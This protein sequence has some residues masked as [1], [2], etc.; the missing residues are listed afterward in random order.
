MDILE[1]FPN[2]IGQVIKNDLKNS[3]F[4]LLEE[5]RIRVSRP[6]VLKFSNKEKE[7]DYQITTQDILEIME[8]ITENSLYSYQKQICDGFITLKG[9]T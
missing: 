7:L 1:Y 3:Y 6:I 5:I 4:N 8:K 9:R 2:R